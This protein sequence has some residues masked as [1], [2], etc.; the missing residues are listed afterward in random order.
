MGDDFVAL[1]VRWSIFPLGFRLFWGFPSGLSATCA[2]LT[3]DPRFSCSFRL[4]EPIQFLVDNQKPLDL[5]QRYRTLG[6]A[7]VREGES[8]RTRRICEIRKGTVVRIERQSGRRVF[9]H[10]EGTDI[11][12]WMSY[13]NQ[14]G[15]F[16]LAK[17]TSK[18][19]SVGAPLAGTVGASEFTTSYG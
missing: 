17:D 1:L 10:F 9:A 6:L 2:L 12:G 19:A 14:L 8:L 18:V 15:H 5:G 11:S 3:S 13:I 7:L 4:E 16:L